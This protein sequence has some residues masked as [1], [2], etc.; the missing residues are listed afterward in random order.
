MNLVFLNRGKFVPNILA[1][2]WQANSDTHLEQRL[3]GA[4]DFLETDVAN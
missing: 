2:F 3:D 1:R 4:L